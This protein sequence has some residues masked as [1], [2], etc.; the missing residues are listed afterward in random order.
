MLLI[1]SLWLTAAASEPFTTPP[2]TGWLGVG[3]AYVRLEPDA[4]AQRVGLLQLGDEVLVR[5]CEPSCDAPGA[6]ALL[7]PFG[8]IRLS[9]LKTAPT[10]QMALAQSA[11]ARFVYGSVRSGGASLHVEPET[12]ALIA[13]RRPGGHVLAFRDDPALLSAGWLR[14]PGGGYM[15]ASRVRLSKPSAFAGEHTPLLPLA[16]VIR[17]IETARVIERYERI[18]VF[19]YDAITVTTELGKLPRDAVRL[20]VARSRPRGVPKNERWV[21]IDLDEQVLAAYEGDIPVFATLVSSGRD[22]HVTKVGLFRVWQKVIHASMRGKS[23]EP[24]FVD[25]VPYTQYFFGDYALHGS[26]W[27]DRFGTPVSH[28]CVN[29]SVAD[30]AW[31]FDWSP[32]TLPHAWHAVLTVLPE[33]P[34]V[35][36]QIDGK[37]EQQASSMHSLL[38]ID[39]D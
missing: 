9:L 33:L 4:K 8:A 1:L 29:L 20:V 36:V 3:S 30:A 34:S 10:S 28:G 14:R 23:A 6:W 5:A 19:D 32:P 12:H 2:F 18:P 26:Y 24:Y 7:D 35:W 11:T 31:L 17:K 13:E 21:H 39:A 16:F 22:H 25:E 15:E 38:S 37:I 27:H